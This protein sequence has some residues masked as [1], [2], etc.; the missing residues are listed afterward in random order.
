MYMSITLPVLHKCE[1]WFLTLKEIHGLRVSE[2]R[3]MRIFGPKREEVVGGCRRLHNK[4]LH[5]LHTS[6][7][8]IRET[9][10]RRM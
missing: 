2:N 5:N 6:A 8:I 1:I 9:K 3:M 4:E 7:N 10:L